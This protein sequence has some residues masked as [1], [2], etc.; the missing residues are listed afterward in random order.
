VRGLLI[1]RLNLLGKDVL[2]P[3][4]A[5]LGRIIGTDSKKEKMVVLTPFGEKIAIGI[6][7][8][9]DVGEKVFLF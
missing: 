7:K 3:S 2:N 5:Y 9:A 8:I 4:G 1:A 6:S